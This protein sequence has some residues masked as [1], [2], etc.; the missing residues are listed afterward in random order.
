MN[1]IIKVIC[2][3]LIGIP[4]S[5]GQVTH[6]VLNSNDS[7]TG[8]LRD[9]VSIAASGDT[10]K[11]DN[12]SASSVITLT[13][14]QLDC[15]SKSLHI[16]GKVENGDTLTISGNESSRIFYFFEADYTSIEKLNLVDGYL[17]NGIVGQSK[18][19]AVYWKG[20]GVFMMRDCRISNMN[21][22]LITSTGAGGSIYA[23]A[24][25]NGSVYLERLI[26]ENNNLNAMA[27]NGGSILASAYKGNATLKDSKVINSSCSTT[28]ENGY[29]NGIV[30]ARS[31]L[32]ELLVEG[33]EFSNNIVNSVSTA[34]V[35]IRGGVLFS[36][37][38]G[39]VAKIIGN[40]IASNRVNCISYWGA[41][42]GMHCN[43]GHVQIKNNTISDNYGEQLANTGNYPITRY[44]GGVHVDMNEGKADFEGNLIIGNKS[45][46]PNISV[47][48]GIWLRAP[49]TTIIRN[50]ILENESKSSAGLF[51]H[52]D[53]TYIV[54]NTICQNIGEGLSLFGNGIFSSN[55]FG[56][57]VSATSSNITSEYNIYVNNP[58][59]TTISDQTNV[60]LSQINLSPLQENGGPTWTK[61]PQAGSVAI[62]RGNPNDESDAQNGP[63]NCIR[64]FGAAESYGHP[65]YMIGNLVFSNLLDAINH[66]GNQPGEIVLMRS[67]FEPSD[68]E[69]PENVTLVIPTGMFLKFI[70]D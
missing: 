28:S 46:A 54:N 51:I 55:I 59:Q 50:T 56:D 11:F 60:S 33:N 68:V 15:G 21:S 37:T 48:G 53:S 2:I 7:G 43:D 18:G 6:Q 9:I 45:L 16:V 1:K 4:C 62:D 44:G 14:G 69:I 31:S 63:I 57:D 30:F 40:T 32:G 67:C 13:S 25:A 66:L 38:N 52:S 42:I 22:E 41:G 24:S 10:I 23:S 8:S 36:T 29:T 58:P 17:T 19:A 65:T 20:P 34:P 64:D 61:I 47:G 39:G 49:F 26:L 27:I 12:L 5:Y 70:E 3:L 35:S